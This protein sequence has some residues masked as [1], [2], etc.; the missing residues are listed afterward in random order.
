[1]VP[2]E[3]RGGITDSENT[4]LLILD[5]LSEALQKMREKRKYPKYLLWEILGWVRCLCDMKIVALDLSRDCVLEP[6]P[7]VRARD[8]GVTCG[9]HFNF[10]LDAF[11][12][13]DSQTRTG[14]SNQ[15][16]L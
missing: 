6:L 2:L 15:F 1:M 13:S 12:L 4:D 11:S 3:Y 5:L 9:N 14:K 16:L 7:L 10:M 8:E